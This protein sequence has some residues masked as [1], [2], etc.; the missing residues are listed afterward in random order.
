LWVLAKLVRE[1]ERECDNNRYHN[2]LLLLPIIFAQVLVWIINYSPINIAR[3]LFWPSYEKSLH[4][5]N[6]LG[7]GG[8]D[9]HYLL[10]WR[11]F[12]FLTLKGTKVFWK[13]EPPVYEHIL[14][15]LIHR[16]WDKIKHYQSW[17]VFTTK[18]KNF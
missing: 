2:A 10:L 5:N 4:A 16:K 8:G 15:T 3:G 18:I 14:K 1:S 11:L 9:S 6:I 12:L 17:V 7:G 13:F